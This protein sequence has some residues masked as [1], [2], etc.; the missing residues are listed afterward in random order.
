MFRPA[1]LRLGEFGMIH[2]PD[3]PAEDPT[4]SGGHIRPIKEKGPV[5]RQKKRQSS[6]DKGKTVKATLDIETLANIAKQ[7]RP[8]Q[9]WYD[10]DFTG[11]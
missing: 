9:E 7:S 2:N 11:L 1:V 8:P 3:S 5:A 4:P 10:E 6:P